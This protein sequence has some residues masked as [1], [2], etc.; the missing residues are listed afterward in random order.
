MSKWKP[1]TALLN[2]PSCLLYYNCVIYI[3]LRKIC[4]YCVRLHLS[5]T[6]LE[7]QKVENG[8]TLGSILLTI[9]LL[10]SMMKYL[11]KRKESVGRK[12]TRLACYIM[13]SRNFTQ[14]HCAIY[15]MYFSKTNISSRLV[16][17]SQ[18]YQKA[19]RSERLFVA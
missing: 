14:Y 7:A 12:A 15:T 1:W 8:Y 6:G 19:F 13:A 2:N 17:I 9:V 18:F 4:N 5:S 11:Y 10:K 3:Y 16:K